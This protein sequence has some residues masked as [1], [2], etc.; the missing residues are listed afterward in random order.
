MCKFNSGK[1]INLLT[2][3]CSGLR[4]RWFVYFRPRYTIYSLLNRKGKCTICGRCCFMNKSRCYYFKDGKCKTYD[5]QPFFCK[6][7]L[8][9][10]KDKLMSGVAKECGYIW[11]NGAYPG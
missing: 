8:I 5:N 11:D 3:L 2:I 7:F 6:I 1:K 4:H 9:D 10:E